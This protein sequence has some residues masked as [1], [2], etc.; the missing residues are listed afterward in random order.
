MVPLSA[1]GHDGFPAIVFK[2][3]P[4]RLRKVIQNLVQRCFE[5]SHFSK[6]LK[7]G[8]TIALKK[9]EKPDYSLVK[10]YRP[11]TMLPTLGKIMEKIVS[12]RLRRHKSPTLY[13][14]T[15]AIWFPATE[16]L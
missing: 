3:A 7:R 4:A 9:P 5:V 2:E 11:I 6:I 8:K 10:A 1:H 16:K 12:R 13:H 14:P 15:R